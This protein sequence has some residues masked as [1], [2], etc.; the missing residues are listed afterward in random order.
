MFYVDSQ[1][2]LTRRESSLVLPRYYNRNEDN[3]LEILPS[4]RVQ[5][6]AHLTGES[7]VAL[8]QRPAGSV[9][10]EIVTTL[11]ESM[12]DNIVESWDVIEKP[13][14]EDLNSDLLKTPSDVI[15][16]SKKKKAAGGLLE[17]KY[18]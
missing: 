2:I 5:S 17:L 8:A 4:A 16:S 15:S 13:K 10:K 7:G 1:K 11:F 12:L 9:R 3:E 18:F 6:T 14:N